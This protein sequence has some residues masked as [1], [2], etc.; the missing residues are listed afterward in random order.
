VNLAV[1]FFAVV[2]V[3]THMPVPEQAP[4]Q[5]ANFEPDFG[6]AVRVTFVPTANVCVQVAPHEIPTGML[7]TSP[8]PVPALA[9]VRSLPTA[10]V[11]VTARAVVIET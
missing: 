6:E 4:D 5:P 10:N 3:R 9:T 8:L 2:I 7:V 11:A 1:T